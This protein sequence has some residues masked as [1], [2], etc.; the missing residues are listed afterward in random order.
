MEAF[1]N[2]LVDCGLADMGFKG[3]KFTWCNG[4]EGDDFTKEHLDKVVANKS[5]CG[6]VVQI[7]C[8]RKCTNRLQYNGLQ[9]RGRTHRELYS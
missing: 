3:P 2:T 9:V 1:Q 6:L 4:R 7:Y 8:T 5:W